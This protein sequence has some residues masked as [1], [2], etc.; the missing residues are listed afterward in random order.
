ME[1]YFKLSKSVFKVSLFI[2][3]VCLTNYYISLNYLV[4]LFT[5]LI[6]S[7]VAFVNLLIIIYLIL[8]FFNENKIDYLKSALILLIN[9]PLSFLIIYLMDII[10]FE[11]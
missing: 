3:V 8:K 10:R 4:M 6:L 2:I 11:F 5:F 9:L 1:K 7:L